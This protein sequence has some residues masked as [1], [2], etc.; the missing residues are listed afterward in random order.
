MLKLN[1]FR[2]RFFGFCH[3]GME[4]YNKVSRESASVEGNLPHTW[5]VGPSAGP[6]NR[7]SEFRKK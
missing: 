5:G 3:Q 1:Y 6:S 2:Y 4:R 7:K